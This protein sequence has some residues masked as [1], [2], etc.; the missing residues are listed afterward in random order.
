MSMLPAALTLAHMKSSVCRPAHTGY[1]S[2]PS[3]TSDTNRG[4]PNV[5][6]PSSERT[7]TYR[8]F[9]VLAVLKFWNATYSRPLR[10]S[11][12]GTENWFSS[13]A[14]PSWSPD[15]KSQN[16]ALPEISAGA[17]QLRPWSSEYAR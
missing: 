6:P 15:W 10:G 16:G 14:V 7:T 8:L 5:A 17:D 4:E 2:A 9:S 13:Q 1:L 12:T 3:Y 11:T